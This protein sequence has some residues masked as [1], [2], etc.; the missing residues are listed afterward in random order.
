MPVMI[1]WPTPKLLGVRLRQR[2]D[3]LREAPG[4]VEPQ[5]RQRDLGRLR[6]VLGHLLGQVAGPLGRP[7]EVGRRRRGHLLVEP[8]GE[9]VPDLGRVGVVEQLL[10]LA[11]RSCAAGRAGRSRCRTARSPTPS[12]NVICQRAERCLSSSARAL[13]RVSSATSGSSCSGFS[14]TASSACIPAAS[15]SADG[16]HV[17]AGRAAVQLVGRRPPPGAAG[18]RPAAGSPTR[19]SARRPASSR[20]AAAAWTR[21]GTCRRGSRRRRGGRGPAPRSAA[22]AGRGRS[23]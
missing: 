20:R 9:L 11:R 13:A 8:V 6:E 16:Q 2:V 18:T 12:F 19:P 4:L 22:S 14:C 3:L 10:G 15:C 5:V 17:L 7:H 1:F 21:R 23:W